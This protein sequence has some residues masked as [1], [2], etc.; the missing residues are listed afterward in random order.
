MWSPASLLAWKD[1]FDLLCIHWDGWEDA[2]VADSVRDEEQ[3]V[4]ADDLLC[5]KHPA[6]EQQMTKST[7]LQPRAAALALPAPQQRN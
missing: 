3:E 4:T 6:R 5:H 1:I 2:A 7:T